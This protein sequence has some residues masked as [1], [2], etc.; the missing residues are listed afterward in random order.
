MESCKIV[1]IFVISLITIVAAHISPLISYGETARKGQF[2]FQ[3][4]IKKYDILHCGA[5]GLLNLPFLKF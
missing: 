4:L 5:V 2:P 3:A 1:F